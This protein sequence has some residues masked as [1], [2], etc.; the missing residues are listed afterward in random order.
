MP[1]LIVT[2]LYFIKHTLFSK[3]YYELCKTV[4]KMINYIYWLKRKGA[5][6]NTLD[7]MVVLIDSDNH[8]IGSINY[9]SPEQF[10][11]DIEKYYPFISTIIFNTHNIHFLGEFIDFLI[12]S[13]K[14]I[15]NRK[16]YFSSQQLEAEFIDF[17]GK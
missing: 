10:R 13:E 2:I 16:V 11:K 3:K 12:M 1:V 17:L 15:E 4:N 9:K 6:M 5:L 14:D 7:K 8:T